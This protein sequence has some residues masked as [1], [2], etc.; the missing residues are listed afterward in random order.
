MP[1]SSGSIGKRGEQFIEQLCRFTFLPDYVF[2][3]P[4]YARGPHVRELADAVILFDRTLVIVQI[5][6]A[7]PEA[8]GGY[9]VADE[10]R[11]RK[12]QTI[13]AAKQVDGAVGA[14]QR[15]TRATTHDRRGDVQHLDRACFDTVYGLVIIDHDHAYPA[16]VE[17]D[18]IG[19]PTRVPTL[20]LSFDEFQRMCT[21][22][23][24][25]GDLLDYFA[26]RLTRCHSVLL[27]NATELDL[28]A[29]WA[30]NRPSMGSAEE[31]SSI[32][33]EG[34]SWQRYRAHAQVVQREG[35]RPVSYII[36][37]IASRLFDS[38][39]YTD[40]S[41][42][43]FTD[44]RAAGLRPSTGF[45]RVRDELARL[46]RV[47]RIGLAE[48]IVEKSR[49]YYESGRPRWFL[50]HL[51]GRAPLLF[52]IDGSDRVTRAHTL[53]NLALAAKGKYSTPY[54]IAIATEPLGASSRSV[55][56]VVLE[57]PPEE[58]AEQ[59]PSDIQDL[60]PQLFDNVR[61]DTFYEFD[62]HVSNKPI[63]RPGKAVRRYKRRKK[64]RK[65]RGK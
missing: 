19:G 33:V 64:S 47:E 43:D 44:I 42:V 40:P 20:F 65:K 24:T 55:D 3:N 27:L 16:T 52:V 5:K 54:L 58:D 36:D 1:P 48:K 45:A 28:L 35:R 10:Y 15:G 6:T 23:T 56:S 46:R 63:A 39:E 9:T 51:D 18:D 62:P 31:L 50:T 49:L 57:W 34:G 60:I 38:F 12:K 17:M 13:K 32:V 22:L 41:T 29:S 61:Y 11:W 7:D 14:L 37:D 26:F 30:G 59:I 2:P 4:T 53:K 8:H 25:I 21:E